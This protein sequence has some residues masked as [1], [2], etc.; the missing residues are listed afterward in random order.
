MSKTRTLTS[1]QQA[2]RDRINEYVAKVDAE[3]AS[4]QAIDASAKDKGELVGR[5]IQEQIGDGY[6]YYRIIKAGSR[7]VALEHMAIGDAWQIP[8]VESMGLVVP[9]KYARENIER[10]DAWTDVFAADSN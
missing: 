1:E 4:M 7:N 2:S 3:F 9:T 5:Y 8:M 6:A 10:R